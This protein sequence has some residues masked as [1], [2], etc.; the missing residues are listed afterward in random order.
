[1]SSRASPRAPAG[2]LVAESRVALHLAAGRSTEEG[3]EPVD[4]A[5][6]ASEELVVG[7][8]QQPIGLLSVEELARACEHLVPI[9]NGE[10]MVILGG[11]AV[12]GVL[13]GPPAM[14]SPH[15][16]AR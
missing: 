12:A 3:V 10:A 9:A 7:Q 1:M 13:P 8:E 5:V 6:R 16:S 4:L 15:R 11:P 14:W 2:T